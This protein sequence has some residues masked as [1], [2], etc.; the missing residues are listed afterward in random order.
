MTPHDVKS[1]AN[2]LLTPTQYA[3]FMAQWKRRLENLIITYAGQANQALVA[4]TIDHLAGE[5]AHTDPNS[6][7]ALPRETLE[8][9]TEAARFAFLKVPDAK[10]PQQSFINIKQAPQE[11]Y[12][13]FVDKLKQALERQIDNDQAR[14]VVLLKLAIENANDDCKRLLKA[15]P[16]EP[17]PTL[18]QMIKAC[19][20]LG[21]LQH[22]TAVTYQAVRQ[23]I[24]D[25][26]AALKIIPKKQSV[27][28]SCG[29]PG[30]IK[31][32][33]RKAQNPRTP[34]M[35]PRCQKGPHFANSCRSKFHKNG[36]PLQGNSSHSA[37]WRRVKT[38]VPQPTQQ[39]SQPEPT[40]SFQPAQ[41]LPAG[42]S[43]TY[44]QQPQGAPD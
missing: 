31:K 4:L 43:P 3:I 29:E 41:A 26:F 14:E 35:C 22:T 5:R 27:C 10:T 19:N 37:G 23:G 30:H 7:A 1:L 38:Q 9:I 33:C 15:L 36:Q 32:D 44:V 42:P 21:T 25:A 20:R 24:A 39:L 13:Q 6:Q 34:N 28:F 16:P 11:P 18:L 8:E 17:E 40:F 12:M 2:L